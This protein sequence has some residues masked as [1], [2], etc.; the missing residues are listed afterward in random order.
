MPVRARHVPP[1]DRPN[2]IAQL[3]RRL[4]LQ[5]RVST[6][7]LA[8]R[9]RAAESYVSKLE[10]GERTV[11]APAARRIADALALAARDRALLDTLLILRQGEA[12]D[13][14]DSQALHAAQTAIHRLERHARS[15]RVFQ[16]ALIPGLLQMPAYME[17]LFERLAPGGDHRAAIRERLR[18]QALLDDRRRSFRF[19]VADWALG[20]H[21]C[22]AR[23]MRAQLRRLRD[24]A[25]QPN[26]DLRVL[27]R[28]ARLPSSIPPLP[29]GF[30]VIDDAIVVL[31]TVDGFWTQRSVATVGRTIAA[32]D[33]AHKAGALA[34]HGRQW[35][36]FD[37]SGPVRGY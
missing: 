5:A 20:A 28:D 15:I 7:E 22:D 34:T 36:H 12:S 6:R 8:R 4:R 31:D 29:A 3:I 35:S 10:L 13:V 24:T 30:E 2:E 11:Q 16:L 19:L 32:F 18:R 25:D 26:V 21:W 33:A 17:A 37:G 14:A 1:R 23:V 27:S 9:I